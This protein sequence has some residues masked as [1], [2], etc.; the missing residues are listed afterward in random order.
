[1]ANEV[2]TVLIEVAIIRGDLELIYML[3]FLL[4]KL[5]HGRV[6]G[7]G[8]HICCTDEDHLHGKRNTL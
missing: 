8:K 1:M 6:C 2:Y 5:Q 7:K 3:R 4:D